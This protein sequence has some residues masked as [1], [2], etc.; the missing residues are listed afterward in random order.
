MIR[1]RFK[2]ECDLGL[3]KRSRFPRLITDE[4]TIKTGHHFL[5]GI[6]NDWPKGPKNATRTSLDRS[7]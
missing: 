6:V 5:C 7:T 2:E 4:F 1:G 3:P